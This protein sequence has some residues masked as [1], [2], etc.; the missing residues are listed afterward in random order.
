MECRDGGTIGFFNL[1]Q[2]F[3]QLKE[4]QVGVLALTIRKVRRLSDD[5]AVQGVD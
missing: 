2:A 4:D 5:Y 1:P 3:V